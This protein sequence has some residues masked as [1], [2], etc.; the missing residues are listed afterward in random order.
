M[1]VICRKLDQTVTRNKVRRSGR[2]EKKK[3]R[4][5]ELEYG[6]GILGIHKISGIAKIQGTAGKLI[7][8]RKNIII[9]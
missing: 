7:N 8:F 9:T 6:T 1:S 5:M 4:N 3:C 2:L